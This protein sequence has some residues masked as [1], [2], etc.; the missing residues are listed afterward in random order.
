MSS[1]RR[2]GRVEL[3]VGPGSVHVFD[4]ESG[5]ALL[6]ERIAGSREQSQDA[7]EDSKDV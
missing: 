6:S 2:G 7:R 1:V 4:A 5:A 3:S